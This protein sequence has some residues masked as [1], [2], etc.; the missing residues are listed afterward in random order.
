MIPDRR[1]HIQAIAYTTGYKY[2]L[3]QNYV[4]ETGI[5]IDEAI[6]TPF[7]W[8]NP[9]GRLKIQRGY[10]WDGPSGPTID[11]RS[12]MRGSLV[13]DAL[14]QLMRSGLLGVDR[15]ATIDR[16]FYLILVEDGMWKWRAGWWHTAVR[17]VAGM[18]TDPSSRKVICYAGV[19]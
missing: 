16:L 6:E 9:N 2:Q 13:H 11:T 1:G 15:R 5:E 7:L 19:R 17:K 18:A 12:S 3:R 14:Y 4:I 8:L 10:A